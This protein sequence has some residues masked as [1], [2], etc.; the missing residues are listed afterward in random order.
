MNVFAYIPFVPDF[1]EFVA[2]FAG[3]WC[4]GYVKGAR[5]KRLPRGV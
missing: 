2:V 3:T 5:R 4:Y 1:L